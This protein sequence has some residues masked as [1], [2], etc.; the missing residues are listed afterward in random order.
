LKVEDVTHLLA[1]SA[2]V[3]VPT[4]YSKVHPAVLI[5]ETGWLATTKNQIFVLISLQTPKDAVKEAKLQFR[6]DVIGDSRHSETGLLPGSIILVFES[7]CF[8]TVPAGIP[9]IIVTFPTSPLE[10]I[11][12]ENCEGRI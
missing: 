8:R 11:E 9:F 10:E 2:K 1:T 3:K 12:P 6:S 5:L 4:V 7:V